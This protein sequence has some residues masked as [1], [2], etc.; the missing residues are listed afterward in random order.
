V[1]LWPLGQDAIPNNQKGVPFGVATL[2]AGGLVPL[3]QLPGI[4]KELDYAQITAAVAIS[5]T[6]EAT[7]QAVVTGNAVTYDGS[8]VRIEIFAPQVDNAGGATGPCIAVIL[9]D[10]TVLGHVDLTQGLGGLNGL[11]AQGVVFDT[12]SAGS[13]TYAWKA[14]GGGSAT[15]SIKAGAGGTGNLVPAY[16]RVTKA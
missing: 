13:H 14:Y 9:R 2:D 3:A 5:A 7:A 10:S 6:T 16:L 1:P 12:P 4:G 15:Y 8:K 11:A